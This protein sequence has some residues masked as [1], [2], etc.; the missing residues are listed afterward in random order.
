MEHSSPLHVPYPP[1]T[2]TH[3]TMGGPPVGNA[4]TRCEFRRVWAVKE[5][6]TLVLMRSLIARQSCLSREHRSA[7]LTG[8]FAVVVL[9][10]F[11]NRGWLAE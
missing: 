7:A 9:G 2:P 4:S 11:V 8:G 3:P 10:G 5:K 6:G 1:T